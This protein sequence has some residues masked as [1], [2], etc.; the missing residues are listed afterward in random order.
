[1]N[2]ATCKWVEIN[3][4]SS[5]LLLR[6]GCF[7]RD[8]GQTWS[9]MFGTFQFL[10]HWKTNSKSYSDLSRF[11]GTLKKRKRRPISL[12]HDMWTLFISSLLSSALCSEMLYSIHSKSAVIHMFFCFCSQTT[13]Q[14]W[15]C[16]WN[17]THL[18]R[19]VVLTGLADK[20]YKNLWITWCGSEGKIWGDIWTDFVTLQKLTQTVESTEFCS[21]Q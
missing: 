3:L 16:A 8:K 20:M 14:V 7:I 9:G 13:E 19:A 2:V 6:D 18:D 4:R 17:A 12:N 21:F 5:F 11:V 10:R 15:N 1:M